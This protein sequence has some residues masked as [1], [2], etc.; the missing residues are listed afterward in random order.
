MAL[1]GRAQILAELGVRVKKRGLGGLFACL[2]FLGE[3]G[4]AQAARRIQLPKKAL[5]FGQQSVE[6]VQVVG[7]DRVALSGRK[8]REC[9]P[10][11]RRR[12][13]CHHGG[14]FSLAALQAAS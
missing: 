8:A 14:S 6:P 4:L 5:L 7:L 9:L 10:E 1:A 12:W 3:R 11:I 13:R 2:R